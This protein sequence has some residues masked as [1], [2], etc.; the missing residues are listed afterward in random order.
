MEFLSHIFPV[1][2]R[3]FGRGSNENPSVKAGLWLTAPAL[4]IVRLA[5]P[6]R[7]FHLQESEIAT[8]ATRAMRIMYIGVEVS[9]EHLQSINERLAQQ[10]HRW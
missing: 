1:K 8:L 5:V 2:A 7:G 6:R 3:A 10:E 4:C 9:S